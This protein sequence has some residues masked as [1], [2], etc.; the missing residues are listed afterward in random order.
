MHRFLCLLAVGLTLCLHFQAAE[1]RLSKRFIEKCANQAKANVDEAYTYSRRESV[2]R[3]KRN[4]ASFAAIRNLGYQPNGKSRQ[5]VRAADYMVN[6]LDVI[7]RYLSKRHR[8]SINA[9]DLISTE[10]LEVIARLT[11]CAAQL[12]NISC[13]SV[14]NL[15]KFR[16]ANSVCNN[17]ENPRWGASNIPFLRWLPAEYEDGI[18]TPKGWT[19]DLRVNNHLLPLVREVSNRILATANSDVETDPLYTH[20]VTIF[21]QW[22]DHDITFTPHSPSI[23]S[24]NDGID[25]ENTCSNTEPCFPIEALGL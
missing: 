3:V 4:S 19:H 6:T 10:D 15:N 8:R 23:R 13:E 11:G 25:C 2:D 20:L 14:P 21:G 18:S 22:T 7:N 9:T 16:T 1:P 17:I 12:E 5:A 24:F